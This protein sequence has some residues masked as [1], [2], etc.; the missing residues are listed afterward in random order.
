MLKVILDSKNMSLYRLEKTSHISHA[1]LNDLYHEKTNIDNCSVSLLANLSSALNID[2]KDLYS[3]L[4]YKDLSLLF[5]DESFDL[6]KSNVCHELNRLK[7]IEFLKKHVSEN[8]VETYFKQNKRLEA[9]YMLSMIDHLCEENNLPL[10]K[11][12]DAVRSYKLN[13]LCVPKSVYLLLKSNT[14]K[15]SDLFNESINTFASHNIMEAH[16]NDVR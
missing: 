1:T 12:Y 15:I 14:V 8:S 6:F 16:I 5:Y 2:M 4:S 10:I 11:E 13:K 7:P 9:L 3:I